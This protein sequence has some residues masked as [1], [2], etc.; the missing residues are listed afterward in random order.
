MVDIYTNRIAW[1]EKAK[2]GKKKMEKEEIGNLIE[3]K[4]KINPTTWS[5]WKT[6]ST[7]STTAL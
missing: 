4:E 7:S 6:S 1:K 3:G 5:K 2:K